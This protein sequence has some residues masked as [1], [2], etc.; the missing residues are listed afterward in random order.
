MPE[1]LVA[2]PYA[3]RALVPASTWLDSIPPVAPIVRVGRDVGGATSVTL[4]PQGA[5]PTWLWLIRTRV[6]TDWT[7]QV[8]P[9]LQR[10]YMIPPQAGTVAADEVAVSAID[11]N[12]NESA[13]VLLS[14]ASP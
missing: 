8:V 1:K 5:E 14:L 11:R 12:G 7:T 6:G 9:G 13:P 4:E 10:F 3:D 2:G